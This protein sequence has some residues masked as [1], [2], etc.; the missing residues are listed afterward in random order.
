[1]DAFEK[2][3]RLEGHRYIAGIDEAGRG[4]LAGPVVAAAVIFPPNYTNPRINDSKKLTAHQREKLYEVIRDDALAV[5]M[6]VMEA[7]VIDR[8]NILQAT[9]LAMREAVYDLS[10]PPDFLLID[11]LHQLVLEIPQKALVKGDTLS[12]SIAAASIIA[13]VS[14]D[15]IMEIYHRKYPQYN[16]VRNKGYATAEHRRAIEEY[17]ICKIHRKSF[18][19]KKINL[20][21]ASFEMF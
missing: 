11:G 7:D 14:R 5:G 21:Q 8:V 10:L 3:A 20:K 9:F 18:S 17:G 6:G 2:I 16:F 1:M 15:R 19:L 4:P 12:V 13:K